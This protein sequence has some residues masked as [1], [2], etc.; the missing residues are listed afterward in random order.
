MSATEHGDSIARLSSMSKEE[1]IGE[2]AIMTGERNAL[3]T[4]VEI[5]AKIGASRE[6]RMS[7]LYGGM[8]AAM[9]LL[10]GGPCP[11]ASQA[12]EDALERAEA[13]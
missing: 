1:L 11:D 10:K 3:M 13:K 5:M 6:A 7:C 4:Q 12:I 8:Y 2:A 9:L